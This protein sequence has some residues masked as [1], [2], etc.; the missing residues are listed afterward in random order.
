ML[1]I[2]NQ[3]TCSIYANCR[4]K[5]VNKSIKIKKGTVSILAGVSPYD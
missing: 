3:V 1:T 4:W 2:H 5:K